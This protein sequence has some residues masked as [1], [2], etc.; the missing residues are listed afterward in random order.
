MHLGLIID[1]SL[2][3]TVHVN[4]LKI[5]LITPKSLLGKLR[6]CNSNE[7]LKTIYNAHFNSLE[8]WL[9][10][11]GANPKLTSKWCHHIKKNSAMWI[12]TWNDKYKLAKPLLNK[13]RIPTLNETVYFYNYLLLST[14]SIMK[15]LTPYKNVLSNQNQCHTKAGYHCEVNIPQVRN[16]H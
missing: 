2:T 14:S 16:T 6:Y 12:I 8:I 10:N 5:K 9:S 15:Y 7:S 13:F 11:L 3:W 4:T 1:E